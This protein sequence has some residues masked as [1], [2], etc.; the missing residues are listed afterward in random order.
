MPDQEENSWLP[1]MAAVNTML[2]QQ[3]EQQKEEHR[4]EIISLQKKHA[5]EL[6]QHFIT[7]G[8]EYQAQID[9]LREKLEDCHRLEQQKDD[10]ISDVLIPQKMQLEHELEQQTAKTATLEE[11]NKMLKQ[12]IQS[13]KQSDVQSESTWGVISTFNA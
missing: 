11:E 9:A 12:M 7:I 1:R 4:N 2:K 3:N 10:Y 13:L 6:N 8:E 5:E